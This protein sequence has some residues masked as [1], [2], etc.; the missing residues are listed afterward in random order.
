MEPRVEGLES[1]NFALDGIWRD[2]SLLLT[3]DELSDSCPTWNLARIACLPFGV[4]NLTKSESISEYQLT[5]F[6]DFPSAVF[7]CAK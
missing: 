7:E 6:G 3:D 5:V 1:P 4:M 2:L